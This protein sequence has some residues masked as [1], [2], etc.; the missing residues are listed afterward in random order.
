[1]DSRFPKFGFLL[2]RQHSREQPLLRLVEHDGDSSIGN[3][4]F[5]GDVLFG[6]SLEDGNSKRGL[7]LLRRESW[8][9]L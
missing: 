7:I 6:F 5:A 9:L 1:M 8:E 2:Q 4:V 3:C